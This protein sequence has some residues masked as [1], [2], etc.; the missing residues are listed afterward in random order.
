[1]GELEGNGGGGG[2]RETDS[3]IT[4]FKNDITLTGF[5]WMGNVSYDMAKE[6]KKVILAWEES[7]GFMPGHTLDKVREGRER[8]EE[9]YP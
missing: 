5:K 3:L 7:I 9:E 8:G 4:G 6:N 1:M 2:E